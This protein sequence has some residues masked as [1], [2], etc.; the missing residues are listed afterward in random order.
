MTWMTMCKRF[1]G[2]DR[3]AIAL[4]FA[5][6]L[7]PLMF[8]VG[9]TIDYSRGSLV[10]ADLQSAA[11]G[12]ILA[13][14][15]ATLDSG[16][17]DFATHARKAF[18]SAF[19]RRDGTTV[20][21][22]AVVRNGATL[23]IEVDARMPL[24]FAG[25]LRQ[26]ALDVKVTA[27]ALLGTTDLEVALVLDNTLSMASD[28]KM[29]A[30][31]RAAKGLIDKLEAVKGPSIRIAVVPFA[32]QVKVP[33]GSPRPHWVRFAPSSNSEP[34]LG[35]SPGHWTGCIADRDQPYD[36][37][38]PR[39]TMQAT[40]YPAAYCNDPKAE[41]YCRG[42]SLMPVMPLT[43]DFAALR[44][45]IDAMNPAGCTNT[46][47]G[48]AWGFS[49][50]TIGAPMS[51]S[52]Q[53]SRADLKKHIVFLTDG[54]NTLNRWWTMDNRAKIDARTALVCDEIKKAGIVLHTIRVMEG[55][56]TLLRNCASDPSLYHSVTRSSDLEP[57][58]N[59]IASQL[60]ALRLAR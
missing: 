22:F 8:G 29:T 46:T 24:A 7:L 52:A 36:T 6:V 27:D 20:T 60:T 57:I 39:A 19:Q 21:R 49:V 15:R 55:N 37:R 28:N 25:I 43:R 40:E 17:G 34:V 3:G 31:K 48:L 44:T 18:D 59:K 16:E 2:E 35:V 45:A 30:L 10:R 9:A 1:A 11:D 12:A 53:Q 51:G 13:A 26:T 54:E 5:L 4:V 33:A 56:Q 42:E 47:I 41:D 58:F 23:T 50:L 38:D 14:G 32:A